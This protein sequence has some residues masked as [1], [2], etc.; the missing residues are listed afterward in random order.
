LVIGAFIVLILR[1]VAGGVLVPELAGVEIQPAADAAYNIA[2]ELL[3]SIAWTVIWSALLLVLLA[4][5]VSPTSPAEK[6]RS[7][8]AVPFGR[9][10]GATFGL[11][12]LVAF[13]FLLMGATDQREFLIRLTIVLL[14]GIGA[15]FF[16]KSLVEAY[17]DAGIEGLSEFGERAK[18]RAGHLWSKRPKSLP[19]RKAG[20]GERKEGAAPEAAPPAVAPAPLS[21]ET[22]VLTPEA[23]PETARLDQLERLADMHGRGILTDEEFASEKRRIMGGGG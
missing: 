8:L 1:S 11:L 22:Q 2:T 17:P 19:G 20:S 14:A 18:A 23:D 4:W 6:T 9:Y 16:R 21:A 12:G 13:I 3:R 5:L 15:F 7:F 10:P